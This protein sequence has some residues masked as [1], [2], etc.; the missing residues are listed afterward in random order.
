MTDLF[1]V[2]WSQLP[3]PEDDG[4]AGHLFGFRLAS[5]PLP[6]TNGEEI[7]L[8]EIHGRAV[9]YIYPMTGRPGTPLPGGWDMLPGARGCTLQA[10][11]FRDHSVELKNV[12]AEQL[13]G[14][15]TQSTE[16][17][18]EVVERLHLPFPLLSDRA[19]AMTNAMQL[20]T[21]EVEGMILLKRLTMIIRDGVIEHIFY[22]VFPP[23]Q[24]AIGVINWL[25]ENPV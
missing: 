17:Q 21:F 10:C 9:V 23:D 18:S 16:Y 12:G 6:A 24:N 4:A 20:P 25:S 5:V 11:E 7:V 3:V 19:L 2:D 22:P 8:S 15:S 14:L 13:Y 1:D